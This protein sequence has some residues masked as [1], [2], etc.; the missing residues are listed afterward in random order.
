[1]EISAKSVQNFSIILQCAPYIVSLWW[2]LPDN[3]ATKE[4]ARVG[5]DDEAVADATTDADEKG[6][7]TLSEG[8]ESATE[9]K[10]IDAEEKRESEVM[11]TE[12]ITV[13]LYSVHL[14]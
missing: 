12:E 6:Q 4:T 8:L 10:K 11:D 2:S 13:F 7:L 5:D 1:L 14:P 3:E 9:T